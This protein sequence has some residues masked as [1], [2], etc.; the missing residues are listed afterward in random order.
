MA[1]AFTTFD[2]DLPRVDKEGWAKIALFD[3]FTTTKASL[4]CGLAYSTIRY[5]DSSYIDM[6]FLSYSFNKRHFFLRSQIGRMMVICIVPFYIQHFLCYIYYMV[7]L[8]H[9]QPQSRGCI[10]SCLKAMIFKHLQI[11]NNY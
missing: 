10:C 5:S 8:E 11:D 3:G 1:W 2:F 4:Y 9:I 7:V 6:A